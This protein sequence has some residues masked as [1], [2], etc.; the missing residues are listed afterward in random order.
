M[1]E[2]GKEHPAVCHLKR[3]GQERAKRK[4]C[5]I[6]STFVRWQTNQKGCHYYTD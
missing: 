5:Y 4:T 3:F 2:K 1:K 6:S